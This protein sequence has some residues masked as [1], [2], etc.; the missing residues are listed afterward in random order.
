MGR[1]NVED[2]V[3]VCAVKNDIMEELIPYS[4]PIAH[5]HYQLLFHLFLNHFIAIIDMPFQYSYPTIQL[6][7]FNP[8]FLLLFLMHVHNLGKISSNLI[9]NSKFKC[10]LRHT[11]LLN[12]LEWEFCCLLWSFRLEILISIPLFAENIR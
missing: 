9:R 4:W 8:F 11:T 6:I 2:G 10:N 1:L 7:N 12:S 5:L 3:S